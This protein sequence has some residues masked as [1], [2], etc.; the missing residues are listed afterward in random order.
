MPAGG[1]LDAQWL[2][3]CPPLPGPHAD[4][5]T[6]LPWQPAGT[7]PACNITGM[8]ERSA[9]TT[10]AAGSRPA[11]VLG[12]RVETAVNYPLAADGAAALAFARELDGGNTPW[13]QQ[14]YP[15]SVVEPFTVQLSGQA[16]R[17]APPPPSVSSAGTSAEGAA[18]PRGLAQA[19]RGHGPTGRRARCGCCPE[20]LLRLAP[21]PSPAASSPPAASRPPAPSACPRQEAATAPGCRATS[22]ASAPPAA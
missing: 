12:L 11:A 15:G 21:R 17:A 14:A 3:A 20:R 4:R 22:A 7:D 8:V 1:G 18:C 10:A 2:V 9:A 19:A 16:T 5:A 6:E 13:L